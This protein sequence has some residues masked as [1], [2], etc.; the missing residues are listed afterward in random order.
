MPFFFPKQKLKKGCPVFWFFFCFR[1][2]KL[3][4]IKFPKELEMM[5]LESPE[6][7]LRKKK[8]IMPLWVKQLCIP[9]FFFFTYKELN[10]SLHLPLL[11]SPFGETGRPIS[12]SGWTLTSSPQA[13]VPAFH[14][15]LLGSNCSSSNECAIVLFFRE[16]LLKERGD[17]LQVGR[18]M[19]QQKNEMVS[20]VP[21][22]I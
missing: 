16:K 7:S 11:S 4:L 15:L 9:F 19:F 1:P 13:L 10:R 3:L 12:G 8:K 5:T 18:K 20:L 2:R 14:C 21:F 17:Y 22:Y 6:W